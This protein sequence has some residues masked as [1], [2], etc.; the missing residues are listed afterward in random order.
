[1]LHPTIL[2]LVDSYHK[3]KQDP[4]RNIIH[5]NHIAALIN[6]LACYTWQQEAAG[7]TRADIINEL[8]EP[9]KIFAQSPFMKRTQS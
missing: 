4:E 6:H 9:R 3:H 7:R 5:Y 2:Q 1:M 8:T